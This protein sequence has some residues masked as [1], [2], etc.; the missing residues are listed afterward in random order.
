MR[1][2][3]ADAITG[4]RPAEALERFA[5]PANWH[6]FVDGFARVLEVGL[7]WPAAGSELTWE[8]NPGGRGQVH[9]QVE[10]YEAPPPAPDVAPQTRPGQLV[11]RLE[12]GSLT[13]T[14]TA[15][16]SPHPSGALVELELDYELQRSGPL[17][18]LTDALFIRRAIRDSLRRTV[19][20]FAAGTGESREDGP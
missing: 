7:G 16:F 12:D 13:G 15:R 17:T 8:S 1:R 2:A 5:D 14:Q 3:R 19:E 18:P 11:T 10:S 4:L 6:S 9:E 20:R